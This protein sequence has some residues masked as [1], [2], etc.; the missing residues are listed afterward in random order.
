MMITLQTLE[1]IA[2]SEVKRAKQVLDEFRE[3]LDA[4]PYHALD[5]GTDAVEAAARFFIWNKVLA[6]KGDR[7]ASDESVVLVFAEMAE[8]EAINGARWPP[9]STAPLGNLVAECTTAT[10]ARMYCEIME[11]L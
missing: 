9:R 2:E 8:R 3:K 5:W 4:D 11:R 6:R 10:W 7:A 1:S